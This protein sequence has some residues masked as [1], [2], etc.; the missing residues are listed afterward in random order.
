VDPQMKMVTT[1]MPIMF[2]V[3]SIFLPAGLTLYILTN[4]ALGMVQQEI[5]NRVNKQGGPAVAAAQTPSVEVVDGPVKLKK[6]KK[7]GP[8]SK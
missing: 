3:F 6:T 2:T 4:T 7:S 8:K 5:I 1:M